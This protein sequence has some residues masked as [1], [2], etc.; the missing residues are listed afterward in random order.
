MWCICASVNKC[1]LRSGRDLPLIPY[2]TIISSEAGLL[3]IETCEQISRRNSDL[4]T[5][6]FMPMKDLRM[7]S[8]RRRPFC[9]E[10]NVFPEYLLIFADLEYAQASS[11]Y[12]RVRHKISRSLKAAK[13]FFFDRSVISYVFRQQ[14]CRNSYQISKRCGHVSSNLFGIIEILC[15]YYTLFFD[16]YFQQKY[17]LVN[18]VALSAR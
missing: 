5:T 13:Y 2:Q 14:Y 11:C 7:L 18:H 8:S 4:Y 12:N 1:I 17:F 16:S 9:I 10:L 15:N 6:S 3:L